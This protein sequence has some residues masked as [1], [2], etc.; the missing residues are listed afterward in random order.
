MWK[1]SVAHSAK[2]AKQDQVA[3]REH[4]CIDPIERYD[5]DEDTGNH[6][7]NEDGATPMCEERGNDGPF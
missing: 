7:A 6:D 4:N 3:N 2:I 5:H 1:D